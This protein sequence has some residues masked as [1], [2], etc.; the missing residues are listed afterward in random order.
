MAGQG[1]YR[2]SLTRDLTTNTAQ[3]FSHR[4]HADFLRGKG[5]GR[6]AQKS[7]LLLAGLEPKTFRAE[8]FTKL[9]L[10]LQGEKNVSCKYHNDSTCKTCA[11]CYRIVQDQESDMAQISVGRSARLHGI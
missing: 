5:R 6:Y 10:Q 1:S 8:D 4:R 9:T 7:K 11:H 2:N 3:Y